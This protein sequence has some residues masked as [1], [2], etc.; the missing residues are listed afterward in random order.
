AYTP[1]VPQQY[2]G[3][4][5][6]YQQ[7]GGY[8]GPSPAG[9]APMGGGM[10]IHSPR[11]ATPAPLPAAQPQPYLASQTAAHAGRPI[12]PWKDSLRLMM[13]IWG[14]IALVTFAIPMTTS[15][16]TFNWDAIIH[17]P[18]KMKVLPLIWASIGL[19]SIVLGAIPMQSMARG[20][21]AAVLGLSGI[22]VPMAVM[23]HFGPWQQ[24]IQLIGVICLVPGLLVRHEYVES[25]LARLLVTIG[26]LCT[27]IP[28]LVPNNGQI[29]LVEIFKG[30]V[31]GRN[32]MELYI[33]ALAQIVLVVMCL[34]A[35]MPGPATAGGKIFAWA[36]ILWPVAAFILAF[37]GM[38]HF[39][40][41]LTKQP[42]Q[43]VQ[44]APG[45]VYSILVGYGVATVV[46]KQLE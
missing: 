20:I 44:W 3:G 15:P 16:M 14:G 28:Y 6:P 31:E 45:V 7:P 36:I 25:M 32:H 43:V 5:A 46:G 38:S 30:I 8:G 27:L 2:G 41:I 11:V 40:E 23:G 42:G 37:V 21:L 1:P 18:G 39:D 26:V 24:L 33:T 13:F 12:E 19:L 4:P 9:T 10:G 34:L 17:A 35:W 22:F 29:P